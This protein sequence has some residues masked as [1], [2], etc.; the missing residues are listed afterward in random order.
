VVAVFS[1]PGFE[2]RQALVSAADG[3]V[4]TVQLIRKQK[5]KPQRSLGIKTG[6]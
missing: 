2:P 3:P 6:R 5:P 1:M 4:Y